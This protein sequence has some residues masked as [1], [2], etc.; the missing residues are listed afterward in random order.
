MGASRRDLTTGCARRRPRW[1]FGDAG[2]IPATSTISRVTQGLCVG[3]LR[4]RRLTTRMPPSSAP[5]SPLAPSRAADRRDGAAARRR[6]ATDDRAGRP[7]TRDGPG[8]SHRRRGE[9]GASGPVEPARRALPRGRPR[10]PPLPR[11]GV[12]RVLGAHRPDGRLP[13]PSSVDARLSAEDRPGPPRVRPGVAGRERRLP[14]ARRWPSSAGAD[15]SVPATSR[16]GP[17]S[18]GGPAAGTTTGRGTSGCCSTSSGTRARSPSSVATGTSASGIWRR[19]PIPHTSGRSRPASW[20]G[21]S[22]TVSCGPAAWTRPPGSAGCSRSGRRGGSAPSATWSRRASR[23]PWRS[24]GCPGRSTRT[25]DSLDRP[26]RGRTTLLSPFDDLTSDRDRT[27][28]LFGMRYRIEIYVPKAKRE[29][30]YFVL[31]ILRGD[32]LVGRLDPAFDRTTRTLRVHSLHAQPDARPADRPAVLRA[33]RRA[34]RVARCRGGH[35]ASPPRRVA[36]R[37]RRP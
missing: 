19:A 36:V 5:G 13:D 8:R 24:T 35:G 37:L 4:T 21:R 29:F 11:P 26:F 6:A 14:Q 18:R 28:R 15:R 12:V 20:R 22:S 10:S 33:N 32:R 7:G 27:E 1:S 31:P 9:D 16:I 25:G 30:G 17:S 3:S 2:S 34:G 23:C